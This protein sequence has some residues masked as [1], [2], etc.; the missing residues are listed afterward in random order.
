MLR[1]NRMNSGVKVFLT[2]L[3]ALFPIGDPLRG[4]PLFLALTEQ[5]STEA[6][7]ALARR[8]ALDS[9]YLMLGSY[10]IG[11]QVL[12]FFGVPLPVYKSAVGW[13]S[14]PWDGRC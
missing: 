6:R 12:K 1:R 13:W 11:A 8:V 4:S 2:I 14:Y 5:Y 3:S 7:R 10:F 9:L